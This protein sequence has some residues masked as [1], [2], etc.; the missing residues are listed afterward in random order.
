MSDFIKL[1]PDRVI[2]K[3]AAGEVIQ[4]PESAVKELIENSIDAD[5]KDITLIIKDSGKTLIRII[6]NGCGMTP[7]DAELCFIRHSTSKISDE[8]DLDSIQ[9]LG[10][11]GEAL[12]SIASIAQVE[13]MTRNNESELGTIVSIENSKIT[14]IS[15]NAMETGTSISVKNIYFNVP[16]RRNFL[17]SDATELKHI[18]DTFLRFAIC[19]PEIGFTLINNDEKVYSFQASDY[20]E[21]ITQVFKNIEQDSLIYFEED[22]DY[23]KF[24][25]FI[26]KP[27]FL[28]KNRGDQY[29][30]L[31]RRYIVNK[32]ISH[33]VFSAYE[34]LARVEG[35][36]FFIIFITI[37]P[38]KVD[39]NVH[40]SKMEVKFDDERSIYSLLK[41][42]IKKS[43]SKSNLVP[44]FGFTQEED[45]GSSFFTTREAQQER[46]QNISSRENV[47]SNNQRD[48]FTNFR[49]E[50]QEK[51]NMEEYS[52]LFKAPEKESLFEFKRKEQEPEIIEFEH[53]KEKEFIKSEKGIWQ[54]DKKYIIAQIKTGIIIIDQHVAHE[55]ILYEKALESLSRKR[56]AFQQLLFPIS[57]TLQTDEFELLKEM[58]DEFHDLGFIMKL[59]DNKTVL[60]EAVPSE[61]KLGNEENIFIELLSDLKANKELKI[62]RRDYLASTFACKAAIKHGD[63]LSKDEMVSLI[64]HLFMTTMPY[65]CPHGRPVIIKIT[66]DDLD[67]KFGRK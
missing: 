60:L 52:A 65:V 18:I 44:D 12:A 42:I 16:A 33:A 36:P 1:L 6:D 29:L 55:R 49:P 35:Y 39:I 3:I 19:Y 67:R 57:I 11:R 47:S 31:N 50:R 46:Y 2:N 45:S 7:N 59:T 13:L 28:K 37:D 24:R 20:D 40:P 17:K 56:P 66:L 8:T 38:R 58:A 34:D 5:A 41:S 43:L 32:A 21:R 15:K 4:R 53:K 62:E 22:L 14:D 30:F 10:F 64:D 51:F 63:L 48:T 61:M 9:T 54:L 26:G 25:G 27:Q 23:I